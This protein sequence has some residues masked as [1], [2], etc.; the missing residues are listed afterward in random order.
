MAWL[1]LLRIHR[2]VAACAAGLVLALPAMASSADT[3]DLGLDREAALRTSQ[4]AIGR[5]GLDAFGRLD[6]PQDSATVGW[7][8]AYNDLPGEG[9]ATFFAAH[10]EYQ[11]RPGV[12]FRLSSLAPGDAIEVTLAAGEV[13]RYRVTSAIEYALGSIDMG[14]ILR[15][16]EGR[17]SITLMTCSGPANEGEYAHRTVVLAERVE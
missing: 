6:V 14:A 15:G 3:T 4:A 8:P 7:N 2:S 16:R 12:F 1:Q 13:Y 17:E 11:G 10:Y 9:G 5:F